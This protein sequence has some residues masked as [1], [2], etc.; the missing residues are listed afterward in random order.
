MKTGE[1]IVSLGW[2]SQPVK[3]SDTDNIENFKHAPM[4]R[5]CPNEMLSLGLFFEPIEVLLMEACFQIVT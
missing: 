1:H 4:P 3:H 2:P 5:T